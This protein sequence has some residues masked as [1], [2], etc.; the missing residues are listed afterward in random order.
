[1]MQATGDDAQVMVMHEDSFGDDYLN[2]KLIP[3]NMDKYIARR[4]ILRAIKDHLQE[5]E[6]T[7]LDIGCGEMPYKELILKNSRVEKYI[8]IDIQNPR[9]QEKSL[10]DL[11]WNG[12]EIPLKDNCVDCVFA[13]EF[14]EHIPEPQRILNEISRDSKT[15][16]LPFSYRAIPLVSPLN[17]PG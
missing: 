2:P 8:A 3:E 6:G 13:T 15:E 16:W 10:P 9:Y 11:F 5:F 7:F 1:M 14:L 17:P 4:S 12:S